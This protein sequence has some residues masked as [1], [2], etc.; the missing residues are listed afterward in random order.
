RGLAIV[1]IGGLLSSLLLTLVVVPVVYAL[2]DSLSRRFGK[3]EKVNYEAE[4]KA[5]YVRN[6]D[7]IDEMDVKHS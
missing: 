3:G 5:D 2:F 4:M 6:E 7:Y 1:I